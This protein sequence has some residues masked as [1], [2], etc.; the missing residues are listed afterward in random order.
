VE[1]PSDQASRP[2]LILA[3]SVGLTAFAAELISL[4]GSLVQ[5]KDTRLLAGFLAYGLAV[6][7]IG[8]LPGSLTARVKVSPVKAAAASAIN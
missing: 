8:A 2:L 5:N 4:L 3:D 1:A 6:M 7:K